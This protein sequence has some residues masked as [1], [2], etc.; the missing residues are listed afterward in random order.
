MNILRIGIMEDDRGGVMK[1]ITVPLVGFSNGIMVG[2]GVVALLA[3]LDIIPRFAQITNTY[4]YVNL[5]ETI[6]V[7][8]SMLASLISLTGIVVNLGRIMVVIVG[9]SIGI[10]IGVLASALAEVL[11]VLPVIIRRFKLEG[12][13]IFIVYSL[14]FG[15][16][17]GS[18]L[19]WLLIF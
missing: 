9:F 19:N 18:L 8:A 5:Y 14:I 3:L 10:F 7:I 12:Y 11:N 2:G 17:L 6:I 13:T 1:Y 16:V 4:D 15:K